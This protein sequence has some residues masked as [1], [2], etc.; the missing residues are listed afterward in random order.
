[1]DHNQALD[2]YSREPVPQQKTL[3]AV[4]IALVI[5]GGT[6]GIP[7]YLMSAN[8]GSSLGLSQALPAFALG[9]ITLG[10]L[11]ALT[12]LCGSSTHLSTY[13]LVE[14]A[15]GRVGAKFV[16]LIIA[17]SLLG[18][19]SV[20][21]NVFALAMDSMVLNLMD[22]S[23]HQAWYI[24]LGSAL[25]CAVTISGFKGIDTLAMMLVPLMLIFLLYAAWVAMEEQ[26]IDS[27]WL[28][29]EQTLSFSA[30]VS[31]VI[32]S[33]IVGVVIQPDYSRF[34]KNNPQAMA[35][36][37]V[38]LG[39]SFPV[40]MLLSAI[41]GMVTNEQDLIK[42]MVILGIG[43]PAFVLLLLGSWSSNV[44]SL[45]SS[46]LSVATIFTRVHLWQII[47]V[48]GSLGTALAFFNIQDYLVNFLLLLGVC[49]PPVASIYSLEILVFRHNCDLAAL[50]DEP[51]INKVAFIAWVGASGF[52]FCAQQG[53]VSLSSIGAIDSVVV[54][55]ILYAGLRFSSRKVKA[56]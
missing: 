30:A 48:I 26:T 24:V 35:A 3:S 8:L 20:T 45:Y 6:I 7:V 41:P 39:V 4:H 13:R 17:V 51:G 38:A 33:Y 14:F 53:L 18:W 22:Q 15:F 40:V 12:S 31:A 47:I 21:M 1:M 27:L 19:Y 37:F 16:N 2:D 36:V 46:S 25:M 42:I 28:A 23:F 32:G 52:G 55:L 49:I 34:A 50:D 54:S 9:C 44:L 56:Q 5:I 43:V 29:N 11:G 10:V